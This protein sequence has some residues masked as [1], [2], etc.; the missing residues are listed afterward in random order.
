[1]GWWSEN[2]QWVGGIVGGALVVGI[3]GWALT[4]LFRGPREWPRQRQEAG[5]GSQQI[6]VDEPEDGVVTRRRTGAIGATLRTLGLAA[7]AGALVVAGLLY[8]IALLQHVPISKLSDSVI[9]AVTGS[10][11]ALWVLIAGLYLLARR[12]MRRRAK[13]FGVRVGS[14]VS[15][16]EQSLVLSI[17]PAEALARCRAA[18]LSLPQGAELAGDS[19]APDEVVGRTGQSE[20]SFGE[21]IRI[22]VQRTGVRRATIEI[23]SRPATWQLFDGGI[24]AENVAGIVRHLESHA[25]AF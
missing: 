22:H 1:M 9:F 25:A 10:V 3:V 5:L 11:M 18:L 13:R 14:G 24:N 8:A 19:A 15:S 16:Y 6:Q 17:D 23:R 12:M 7:L 20:R 2:Y 21:I 4:R